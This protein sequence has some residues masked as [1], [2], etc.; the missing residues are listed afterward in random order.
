MRRKGVDRMAQVAVIA[1]TCGEGPYSLSTLSAH[2]TSITRSGGVTKRAFLP[3]RSVSRTARARE[4]AVQ[5]LSGIRCA[6]VFG[7]ISDSGGQPTGVTE[8]II[9]SFIR[10]TA[11]PSRKIRTSC[12][13][14]AKAFAWRKAKA[15][16][17]GSSDPHAL[18]IKTFMPRFLLDGYR[19]LYDGSPVVPD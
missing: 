16:F 15:A 5:M 8:A 18:L 17:V 19:R 1:S 14:S 9:S 10:L 2:C 12:P 13:A 7:M 11:S 4:Q 3:S 6:I